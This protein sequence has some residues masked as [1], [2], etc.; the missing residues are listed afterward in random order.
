[1]PILSEQSNRIRPLFVAMIALVVITVIVLTI[2]NRPT[3]TEHW[4]VSAIRSEYQKI[5]VPPG[6][7]VAGDMDVLTKYGVNAVGRRYSTSN[8]AASL[9]QHYRSELTQN[10]WS[11]LGDFHSGEHW[12]ESYCKRKLLARIELFTAQGPG[13]YAFSMSWGDVSEGQCP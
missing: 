1:V 2:V 3:P 5:G 8:Q 10:G 13:E 7:T 4:S 12:G 11:Y 6:S 9:L